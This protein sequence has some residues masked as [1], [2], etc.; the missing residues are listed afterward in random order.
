MGCQSEVFIGDNLTF[1][2]TCHD[3]DTGVLTDADAPP[4]YR[5]YEDE[6]G[7]AILNGNM[8]ILDNA[9][10]TGFYSEL[11]NCT[12]GNGFEHGRSYNIY[13]EATVDG[14]TGGISYGF[15]ALTEG[16]DV[17]TA[18]LEGAHT[19]EEMMRIFLAV[20]AGRSTGGGT[21]SIS[22]RDEADALNRVN[23]TVD[24]NG[25]RTAINTLN[26]A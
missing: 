13:I 11:I 21:N 19:A 3:P 2:I 1:T 8:A 5:V 14:D 18:T 6:T 25:N 16:D 20:L 10:T 9:N 15:R 24:A 23:A 7:A 12:V 4:S 22:F 17:W 26:G